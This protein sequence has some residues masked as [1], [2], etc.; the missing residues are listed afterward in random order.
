[1][2]AN[3]DKRN[4]AGSTIGGN[5]ALP[6]IEGLFPTPENVR[7]MV[8]VY[9]A[10][11]YS[12]WPRSRINWRGRPPA[13]FRWQYGSE[14]PMTLDDAKVGHWY[15]MS[16][17]SS[18]AN[19]RLLYIA[20][21]DQAGNWKLLA[22]DRAAAPDKTAKYSRSPTNKSIGYLGSA[23]EGDKETWDEWIWATMDG[24][25]ALSWNGHSPP[26]VKVSQIGI[27]NWRW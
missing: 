13:E 17:S 7:A 3:R 18:W 14:N 4:L 2:G 8:D 16:A 19:Y 22:I 21:N 23:Y 11:L 10:P 20:E 25:S 9:L 5:L 6:A 27:I 15:L 26:L 12:L 24:W 1:M